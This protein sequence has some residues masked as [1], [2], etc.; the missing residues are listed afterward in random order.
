MP[1]K[2]KKKIKDCEQRLATH[3]F[4]IGEFYY[5]SRAFRAAI[6]RLSEL[7]TKYPEFKKM[8]FVYYYIAD[9]YF[10]SKNYDQAQPYFTKL[11]SDYPNSKL[12]K[13]AQ[14]K[15]RVLEERKKPAK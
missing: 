8:D 9:S 14:E 5:K 1:N 7:M 12:V 13:K 4:L 6:G 3:E 2:L 10:Q 15:L 11:V